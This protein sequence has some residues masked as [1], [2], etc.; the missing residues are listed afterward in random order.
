MVGLKAR[1]YLNFRIGLLY[2]VCVKKIAHAPPLVPI[3]L[4]LLHC[5]CS[6]SAIVC[7]ASSYHMSGE[8]FSTRSDCPLPKK[9]IR[10]H[11]NLSA[12][13][14]IRSPDI[15][16]EA[17]LPCKKNKRFTLSIFCI[18]HRFTLILKIC[19]YITSFFEFCQQNEFQLLCWTT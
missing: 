9:S 6:A 15:L 14:G 13:S 8:K 19:H 1:V 3:R 16:E 4:T 18:I 12:Y 11:L 10:I 17:V 2:G 5:K 7:K